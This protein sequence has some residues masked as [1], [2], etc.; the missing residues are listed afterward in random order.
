M[1]S[2]EEEKIPFFHVV[3]VKLLSLGTE[4]LLFDGGSGFVNSIWLF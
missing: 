3:V 2:G 1:D 4:L